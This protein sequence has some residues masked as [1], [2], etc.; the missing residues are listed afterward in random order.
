MRLDLA[1][2]NKMIKRTYPD[3]YIREF[4][5]F[6]DTMIHHYSKEE[7]NTMYWIA[8]NA[9]PDWVSI[10]VGAH[11]GEYTMLLNHYCPDGITYAFEAHA[12][13]YEMLKKNLAYHKIDQCVE[14]FNIAVGDE[15]GTR[16][17]WLMFAGPSGFGEK[18]GI[19]DFTTLDFFVNE[20]KVPR[21][22]FIKIDV[23]GW[24]LEVLA[25]AQALIEKYHPVII[26]E[27]NKHLEQRKHTEREFLN[28]AGGNGYTLRALDYSK[29]GNW[30]CLPIAK[31]PA[32]CV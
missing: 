6:Y 23:D 9:R 24:D 3:G 1:G 17:T 31:G 30:L 18:I 2:T 11:I 32:L 20:H 4:P 10:D 15:K 5:N 8:K 14:A 16:E 26:I 7:R 13:T 29:S 27:I 21:V 28:F 12:T 19:Y 22:D 25:G